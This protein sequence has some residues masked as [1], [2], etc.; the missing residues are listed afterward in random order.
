MYGPLVLA[1]D[2]GSDGIT[3]DMRHGDPVEPVKNHFLIG[4]PAPV[5]ALAGDPKR[6]DTWIRRSSAAPLSFETIGQQAKT[7]LIPL[8]QIADQRYSI[9]WR[10]RPV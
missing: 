3:D 9:Y 6:L 2:L 7:K 4:N 5:P 8:N 1:G 10:V